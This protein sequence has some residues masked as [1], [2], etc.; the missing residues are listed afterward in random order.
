MALRSLTIVC[1][2]FLGA[3]PVPCRV[4]ADDKAPR[5]DPAGSSV[6]MGQLRLLFD[7]WDINRDGVLDRAELAKA[8]RGPGARPYTGQAPA[9]KVGVKYPDYQFLIQVD[10]N[11]DGKITR[12]EFEDWARSYVS[13]RGRVR[14]AERRL[15]SLEKKMQNES[16]AEDKKVLAAEID[17]QKQ[18][19]EAQKKQIH[20]IETV[21][22]HLARRKV[23]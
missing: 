22:K 16:R 21:E 13:K 19:L 4:H 2:I 14:T 5:R 11:N 3:G 18:V 17:R 15:A 6:V 23:K 7:S 20:Y 12:R 8:F 10:Q 9:V 1:L